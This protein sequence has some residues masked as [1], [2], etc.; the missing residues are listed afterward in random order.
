[1]IRTGR[2]PYLNLFPLFYYLERDHQG[3]YE[4]TDGVPSVLNKLLRAGRIDLS[5][6]SSIEYLRNRELYELVPGHSISS[7][8]PIG[9][10]F[11]FSKYPVDELDRKRIMYLYHSETSVGLLR[12]ICERFYG[13]RPEYQ[14]T[15]A[16]VNEGLNLGDAYLLIGDQAMRARKSVRDCHVYDLGSIWYERTGLPFVF[17]LWIGNSSNMHESGIS[18]QKIKSDLD[19]A[20]KKAENS[21]EDLARVAPGRDSFTEEEIVEYWRGISFGLEEDHLK[22]LRRFEEYLIE[23]GVL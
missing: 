12:I 2:I 16:P 4:F 18:V 15:S 14:S 1:M 22:G 10:I 11:L 8:G 9:S 5:P 17:A 7:K 6:S 3:E 13:L 23:M 20:L 19:D 21:F